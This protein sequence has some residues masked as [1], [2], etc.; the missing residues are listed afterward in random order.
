MMPEATDPSLRYLQGGGSGWQLHL[1]LTSRMGPRQP[2]SGCYPSLCDQYSQKGF[3]HPAG[4]V[5]HVEG[6]KGAGAGLISG[7]AS[8]PDPVCSSRQ[9]GMGGSVLLFLLAFLKLA[10][11]MPYIPREKRMGEII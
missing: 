5:S 1:A 2:I 10:M 4:V 3:L 8:S 6:R 7:L 9:G 11:T